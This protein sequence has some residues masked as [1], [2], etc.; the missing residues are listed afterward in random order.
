MLVKVF[1]VVVCTV[2]RALHGTQYTPQLGDKNISVVKMHGATIKTTLVIHQ[3]T[4]D[5]HL[6]LRA[7]CVKRSN[8]SL[9][10]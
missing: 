1:Q 7:V 4:S 10:N 3:R 6:H 8:I 9:W 5:L 2:C